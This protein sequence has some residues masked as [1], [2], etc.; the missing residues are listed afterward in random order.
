MPVIVA[1]DG[2]A[3][4]RFGRWPWPRSLHARLL[5]EVIAGEPSAIGIDLLFAES[6]P[7]D[8]ELAESIRGGRV[9]LAERLAL[10]RV[11]YGEAR[12]GRIESPPPGLA[13]AAFATGFVD[14]F[15]DH[16]GVA[17][18]MLSS[19]DAEGFSHRSLALA[20][21]MAAGEGTGAPREILLA[22]ALRPTRWETISAAA[23][24]EKRANPADWRGRPVLI[25]LTAPGI[26]GDS[27]LAPVRALGSV[28]GVYLHAYAYAT[29]TRWGGLRVMP[30]LGA[31]LLALVPSLMLAVPAHAGRPWLTAGGALLLGLLVPLGSTRVPVGLVERI[32][33][34]LTRGPQRTAAKVGLALYEGDRLATDPGASAV[35]RLSEHL[36]R[37]GPDTVLLV[38][39]ADESAQCYSISAEGRELTL[40]IIGPGEILGEVALLDG[41]ERTAGAVAQT[42][43][44]AVGLNRNQ[45]LLAIAS[46]PENTLHLIVALCHRLRQADL[47]VEE[48]TFLSVKDRLRNLIERLRVRGDGTLLDVLTHQEISEMIGTSRESVTRALA[49][50]RREGHAA[51]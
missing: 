30:W 4:G 33:G 20:L 49:D 51:G 19:V 24:L 47:M 29:L 8:V 7:G 27:Y 43:V 41:G 50:L 26:A 17:R 46:H 11:R 13:S 39:R 44:K 31:C 1:I 25:G 35:I 34:L 21:A 36:V 40:A 2:E 10:R 42:E 32:G 18:R 28:P 22:F 12:P 14:F 6:A 48:L 16:D 38:T 37:M 9:V 5:R 3:L 15:P 23:V 45:F